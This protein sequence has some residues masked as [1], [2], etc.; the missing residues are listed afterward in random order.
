ML[1]TREQQ[2]R[3]VSTIRD[4]GLLEQESSEYIEQVKAKCS[5]PLVFLVM[6]IIENDARLHKRLQEFIVNTLEHE[7]LT[8][9][10][11]EVDEVIGLMRNHTR[12]K[13]RMVEKVENIM[14]MTK[15]KSLGIQKFLLK[16]LLADEKKHKEMLEGIEKVMQG[17]YPY[18]P[19]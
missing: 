11:D 4:W 2:Q 16:T 14:E 18:W 15:D 6:D 5:N 12:L 10:P 19:H 3:I 17:L 1:A 9:S 8:L 13:A 7:P